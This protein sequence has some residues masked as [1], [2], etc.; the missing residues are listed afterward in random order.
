MALNSGFPGAASAASPGIG[1]YSAGVAITVAAVLSQYFVPQAVPFLRPFYENLAGGILVVYG[2]PIL[3]FALLVGS[4]PLR[5]FADQMGRATWEG[6]RWYGGLS[7]LG[8]LVTFVLVAVYAVID[9]SALRLLGRPNPVIQEA[10]SNPWFYVVFSFLVGAFEEAIFRGWIFGFWRTRLGAPW[11]VHATWTSA[12]FAGVHIYYAQTYGPASP[13]VYPTL[14]LLGFAF[15]ATYQLSGGNLVVVIL[16]HGLNDAAG[17]LSIV[18]TPAG[19]G[20]H[21]GIILVGALIALLHALGIGFGARP[22]PAS[23]PLEGPWRYPPGAWS[24]PAPFPGSPGGEPI[25]PP[26]PPPPPPPPPPFG[27]P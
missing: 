10:Q 25:A 3:A 7:L 23:P 5:S 2:I 16:L 4:A 22:R 21:Y 12:L 17:F 26:A 14:F 18:S 9:P 15:A 13:L 19:L 24:G 11:W 1:R 20:L 27:P 8:L 6:L